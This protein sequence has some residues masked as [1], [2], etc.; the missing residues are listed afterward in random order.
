MTLTHHRPGKVH[1]LVG[2]FVWSN[3]KPPKE[4]T[5]KRQTG[6]IFAQIVGK[7]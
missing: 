3:F 4:T 7:L 6:T 5:W 1:F 2:L